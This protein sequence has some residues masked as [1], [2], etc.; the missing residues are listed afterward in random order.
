MD[1]IELIGWFVLGYLMFQLVCA[2]IAMQHIKHAVKELILDREEKIAS[3][4]QAKVVRFERVIQGPYDVT[5]AFGEDNKFILQ[6]NTQAEA[7]ELLKKKYP[8]K[9]FLVMDSNP[10]Q[11]TPSIDTKTV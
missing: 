7:E 11:S 4:E 3:A 6:G 5:L 9:S 2:W 1:I 8:G 10:P